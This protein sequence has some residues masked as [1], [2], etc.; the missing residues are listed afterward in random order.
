MLT[1]EAKSIGEFLSALPL[2]IASPCLNLGSSTEYFR[3]IEQPCIEKYIVAPGEARGRRFIHAD[4]KEAPGVDM[5]GDIYNPEFEA[6]LAASAPSSVLCCNMF[7]HVLDRPKLADIC[8]TLVR[9]GGYIIVS[10]P[11]S[12]PYHI[13]PIDTYFRPTPAEIADLFSD[14]DIVM[15]DIV[16]DRTYWQELSVLDMRQRLMTL[17]KVGIHFFLPFYKWER[18][19]SRLHPLFWLFRRY[20]VS[21]VVLKRSPAAGKPSSICS[22]SASS[23]LSGEIRGHD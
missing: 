2:S 8:R 21:I 5:A 11:R 22:G 17:L 20:S 14:C 1:N 13:D 16:S 23:Y 3:K 15:A 7:E 19:K 4:I 10:V 6:K 12:F 9:P 18:W